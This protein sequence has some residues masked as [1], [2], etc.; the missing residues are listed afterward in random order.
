MHLAEGNC[1]AVSILW[2]LTSQ[3][4]WITVSQP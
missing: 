1:T 3:Q 4:L 2:Y